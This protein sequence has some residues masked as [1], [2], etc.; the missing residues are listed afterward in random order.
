MKKAFLQLFNKE[1]GLF[2]KIKEG[3]K[4]EISNMEKNSLKYDTPG[5]GHYLGLDAARKLRNV[6][7]VKIK[8]GPPRQ[9]D[10]KDTP[11]PGEYEQPCSTTSTTGQ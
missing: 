3:E 4:E 9:M 2:S 8:G 7:S 1:Q 5:P 6:P 10:I 11:G